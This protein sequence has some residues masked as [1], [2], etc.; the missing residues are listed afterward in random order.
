MW[1]VECVLVSGISMS[2]EGER[3][4]MQAARHIDKKS[5]TGRDVAKG[6]ARGHE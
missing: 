4:G 2:M 3:T 6:A 5:D 1:S